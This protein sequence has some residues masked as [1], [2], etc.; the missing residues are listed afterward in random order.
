MGKHFWYKNGWQQFSKNILRRQ[1]SFLERFH[2]K[3]GN[4]SILQIKRHSIGN[5][6][7][8]LR[9]KQ[10]K[11]RVQHLRDYPF[12]YRFFKPNGDGKSAFDCG[13]SHPTRIEKDI[14]TSCID[15]LLAVIFKTSWTRWKSLIVT[16]CASYQQKD[17]IFRFR[18][19]EILLP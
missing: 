16:K 14:T 18:N 19:V 3:W 10:W 15:E 12:L 9:R 11:G 17:A 4:N 13:I 5:G 1:N 7:I 8:K 2:I 6:S